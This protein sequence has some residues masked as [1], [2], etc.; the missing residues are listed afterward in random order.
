VAGNTVAAVIEG[1]GV[2]E[3]IGASLDDNDD[4]PPTPEEEKDKN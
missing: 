1:A 3:V 2:G 4:P